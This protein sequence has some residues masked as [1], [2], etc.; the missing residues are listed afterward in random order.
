MVSDE[1]HDDPVEIFTPKRRK[2]SG[3][4][5][6]VLFGVGA[7][8]LQSTLAASLNLNGG[9]PIEFGQGVSQTVACSGSNSLV[10]TPNSSF[11]N[12]TGSGTHYFKS[13]TVSNIPSTC[14]G[15]DFTFNAYG[16]SGNNPLALY[17]TSMTGAVVYDNAGSFELGIRSYQGTSIQSSSGSF[18]LTFTSPVANSASVFK[19]VLQSS[20]HT[21]VTCANSPGAQCVFTQTNLSLGSWTTVAMSADGTHLAAVPFLGNVWTSADSGATWT[22]QSQYYVWQAIASSKDGSFIAAGGAQTIFTSADS[23]INWVVSLTI[24]GSS[25]VRWISTSDDGRYVAAVVYDGEIYTS[26]NSGAS[27]TDQ[28]SAGSRLWRSIASSSDGSRLAAVAVNDYI[29]TSVNSGASW[30]AQTN[31]GSRNW[32]SI[33]SNSAGTRLVALNQG[34]YI[35]RSVDSGVNWTE[36]T[37]AGDRIWQAITSSTDGTHLAAVAA[38]GDIYLSTD[39]GATWVDQAAAGS[40]SWGAVASSSDGTVIAAIA[41]LRIYISAG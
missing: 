6:L 15:A 28:T 40:R 11:A 23:G 32:S 1:Y 35:Y 38:S 18:T 22:R 26:A 24:P 20:P 2:T 21:P 4:A 19:I 34:G 3:I 5:A 8:Y 29:W 27:W 10:L 16:N 33:A 9:S 13:V 31:S 30:T 7:F 39:S 14:Q 17:N 37:S 12:A 41:D 25:N 36:L